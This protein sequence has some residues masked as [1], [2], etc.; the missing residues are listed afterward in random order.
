MENSSLAFLHVFGWHAVI[1]RFAPLEKLY[2]SSEGR[3]KM[4][5]QI[6]TRWGRNTEPH[7]SAMM[8]ALLVTERDCAGI[9]E[10]ATC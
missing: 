8:T 5:T 7:S 2:Y 10:E 9:L 3:E 4:P 1:P 6:I